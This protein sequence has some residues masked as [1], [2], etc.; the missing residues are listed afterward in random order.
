VPSTAAARWRSPMSPVPRVSVG[1]AHAVV[2][3]PGDERPSSQ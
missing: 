3:H 2:R 1:T